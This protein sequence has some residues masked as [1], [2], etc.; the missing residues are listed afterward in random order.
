MPVA[1][2]LFSTTLPVDKVQVGGIIVPAIGVAGLTG[3]ELITTLEDV[4]EVHPD[5]LV[6][7]KE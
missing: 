7:K 1:D 4:I 6:T 3:G 5:K 2:K